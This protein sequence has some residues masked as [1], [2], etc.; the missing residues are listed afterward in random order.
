MLMNLI[1][2]MQRRTFKFVRYTIQFR[3]LLIKIS[4]L[5][6]SGRWYYFREFPDWFVRRCA[7]Y[8]YM[9]S[10]IEEISEG[11]HEDHIEHTLN[12]FIAARKEWQLR[13]ERKRRSKLR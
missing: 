13:S 3:I 5:H 8:S 9:W 1:T 2:E 4:L 6:H 7:A 10:S 12:M 11:E